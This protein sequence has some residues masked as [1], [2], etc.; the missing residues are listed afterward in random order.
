MDPYGGFS[1]Q[2]TPLNSGSD[3]F[4]EHA[5][6]LVGGIQ[7]TLAAT[8]VNGNGGS[9]GGATNIPLSVTVSNSPFTFSGKGSGKMTVDL[10]KEAALIANSFVCPLKDQT[11]QTP[12]IWMTNVNGKHTVRLF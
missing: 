8:P 12:D 5:N 10:L 7:P 3:Q 11:T 9:D 6:S 2:S 4:N 1:K